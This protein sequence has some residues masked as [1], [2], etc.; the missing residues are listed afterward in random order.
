VL[1]ES[2]TFGY[3]YAHNGSMFKML[4]QRLADFFPER[5]LEIVNLGMPAISSFALPVCWRRTKTCR[6][7]IC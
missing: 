3:P 6:R 1:G 5:K 4:D 2:S 7:R